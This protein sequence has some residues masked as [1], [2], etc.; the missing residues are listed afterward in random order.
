MSTKTELDIQWATDA[1]FVTSAKNASDS[2]QVEFLKK[3]EHYNLTLKFKVLPGNSQENG[4][5]GAL[6]ARHWNIGPNNEIMSC[7]CVEK[8]FPDKHIECPV[9]KL[10]RELLAAG[11]KPEDLTKPGAFGPVDI[12]APQIQTNLKVVMI[13]S[14]GT[15]NKWDQSHVSVL[16]MN[17]DALIKWLVQ[18]YLSEDVPNF[19]DIENGNLI[20]FSRDSEK[21]KWDKT[22]MDSAIKWD[23]TPETL[24]KIKAENEAL[25]LT[26][27]WKFPSDE[28]FLKL[29][30]VCA[31]WK[32]QFM[33]SKKLVQEATTQAVSSLDSVVGDTMPF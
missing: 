26:D 27:L 1:G 25:T 4:H 24:E 15:S 29:Q 9:C 21:S 20:K 2:R 32:D 10:K 33:A 7:L 28:E 14:D 11:F 22:I 3:K 16:T 31:Q 8:M 17:G 6:T 5:L 13:D 12:F 30:N 23:H 18:S 19:L